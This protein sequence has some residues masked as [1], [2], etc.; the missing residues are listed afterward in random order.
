MQKIIL[1]LLSILVCSQVSA[2]EPKHILVLHSYNQSMGWIKDINQAINDVLQPDKN[3]YILH[4]ENMD[5]KRIYTP[6]HLQHLKDI[7][8]EK[9]KNIKF[10]LIL[11]SDNNAFDFLKKNRDELFGNI[12]VSFSGVNFFKPGDLDGYT[13]Y[14]GAAEVFDART[15]IE[16]ALKMLP[17][18]K[19]IYVINDYLKTG[20]TWEKSIKLQLAGMDKNI[21]EN[22]KI[23]YAANQPIAQLRQSLSKLNK[24]TIILLGVYFKDKNGEY[25]TYEKGEYFPYEQT[26]SLLAKSTAMPVFCL[27][28]FNLH[29]GV[30]GGSVI[31][32][33][34][35]GEAMSKIALQILKGASADDIP[36]LQRGSTKLIYDYPSLIHHGIDI[37]DVNEQAFILNAPISYWQ[38]NKQILM[39]SLFIISLLGMLVIILLILNK[40]RKTAEN[41]FRQ[42]SGSLEITV[43][44]RTKELSELKER[45]ELALESANLG[46]WDWQPQTNELSTNDIF[47]TMLGYS[48]DDFPQTIE[49]RSSL[50]HPDDIETVMSMLSPFV[51]GDD[52]LYSNEYR[53]LAADKTWH[54][55][56]DIGRVVRRD[57]KG[58]ATRFI[59]IHLD[60]TQR[61]LIEEQLISSRTAADA[62]NKA[63]SEFLANMS[64]ELRTPMNGVLGLTELLAKT[65]LNKMQK[66]YLDTIK[67]SGETLLL[68]LNDILDNSKIDSGEIFFQENNF[69][70]IEIVEHIAQLLTQSASNKGIELISRISLPGPGCYAQGDPDRIRQ[71]LMNLANNAI[72]FTEQGKV[73]LSLK[74]KQLKEIEKLQCTFEVTDT[75]IGIIEEHQK[76]LFN[77]FMQVDSSDTRKYMG[78]GLGLSISKKLVEAMGGKIGVRSKP[79]AGSTFWFCFDLPCVAKQEQL[80]EV[81]S[82]DNIDKN[83]IEHKTKQ[84]RPSR[85]EKILIAEDDAINQMVIQG[86][87]SQLGFTAAC[88][89]N[90]QEAV[91]AFK[92]G[93]YQLILMDL[94]MPLMG[95]NEASRLI[96]KA[97][98]ESNCQ[99]RIP[100]LALTA[101]VIGGVSEQTR[102]AGMD[103]YLSKPIKGDVIAEALSKWLP[104]ENHIQESAQESD[105]SPI[106]QGRI[107]A[108]MI[109]SAM[110]APILDRVILD[111]ISL[112]LG[113]KRFNSMMTQAH[114]EIEKR[115]VTLNEL[116]QK[117]DREN[118]TITAHGLRGSSATLGALCLSEKCQA[119]EELMTGE[120]A[121]EFG[122]KEIKAI[123]EELNRAA[124]KTIHEIR[125]LTEQGG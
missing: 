31:G 89:K 63:K 76:K 85:V 10:D 110:E 38:E 26:G 125:K 5:T 108:E 27:L 64:H 59:G 29:H 9:Y 99:T 43:K 41:K 57:T 45:M 113:K 109:S 55:I 73:T 117:E 79:G 80:P 33:Y 50:V 116:V 96:R 4:I 13:N 23:S 97:E 3:N 30:V 78:T 7:Y 95:G 93:D 39:V 94:Q 77:A 86:M 14:T 53:M 24:D 66:D 112:S 92:E 102:A 87:L 101:N 17:Q 46:L 20:R 44:K 100:I 118:L 119:L 65:K 82:I 88:V 105:M 120:R 11:S 35:Q 28:E 36:V 18:T 37:D 62:A 19:E 56:Y 115:L 124:N 90:G 58:K 114:S 84:I 69:D 123:M 25:F 48:P 8:Q 1:I 32:G 122:Q 34:Y 40:K 83:T 98:I 54:W 12:P 68:I 42:L 22:I 49:R 70:P 104:I 60:I 47:L 15:T 67:V 103:D 2:N 51:D 74:L 111:N 106:I 21:M 107:A 121:K 91:Q 16:N 52:G 81:K 6:E 71:I 75:G 61:K 72:K